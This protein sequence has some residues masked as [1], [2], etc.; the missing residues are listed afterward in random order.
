MRQDRA[1]SSASAVPLPTSTAS[2]VPRSA[3]ARRRAG[4]PVIHWLSPLRVAMRP[5][6]VLAS[7]SVSSG[8]LWVSRLVKPALIA[9]ASA[10][11][12][13]V[14]T[15]MPAARSCSMPPPSTRGSGSRIATT[16]RAT[17]AAISAS[18]Q[19]GVR[20]QWQQGSSVT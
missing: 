16:T 15:A 19:G 20:P 7:F 14:E 3:C 18:V 2:C 13:P 8:R 4:A 5:S 10:S 11:S 17:P 1:G 12:S 6:S 9:R